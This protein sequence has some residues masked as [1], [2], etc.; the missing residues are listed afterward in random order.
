MSSHITQ[1][2]EKKSLIQRILF[3]SKWLL[4]PFYLGLMVAQ[5]FYCFKFCEEVWHLIFE[6][7]HLSEGELMMIVLT[8]IDITMVANLVKMIIT[9][10]YQT[11]IEHVPD[12]SEH[13]TSGLLKVKMGSSLVGIS[14]IHLLQLFI[15]SKGVQISDHDL[16]VK[17]ALHMIF[18][19]S[20]MG[21][22]WIDFLH[23]KSEK[24]H[25]A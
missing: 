17:S 25:K 15:N 23:S 16:I 11:F 12:S 19:V 21:L 1:T 5:L 20:T 13:V 22:A 9:G 4:T 8:L 2:S 6:F 10:S 24:F 18:L 3:S 14:S 7:R